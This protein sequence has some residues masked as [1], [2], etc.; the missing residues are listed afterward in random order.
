MRKGE[1][2]TLWVMG[3]LVVGVM[4]K[5]ILMPYS[6]EKDRSVPYYSTASKD[7]QQVG[8]DIIR[9]ESCRTCHSLMTVK[10]IMNSVPAPILDG[11]GSLHNEQWFYAYFSAPNPQLILPSRLKAEYSMPS[12]SYLP[13]VQRHQLAHY[14]ASLKVKDWYL[15]D[16]KK[17]EHLKLTGE[18]APQNETP[19]E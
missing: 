16:T 8:I 14:M 7:E 13:D 11:L 10:N 18:E 2:V 15:E 9:H 12:Y 6:A 3:V 4:L 5:N 1:K 19:N 17:A